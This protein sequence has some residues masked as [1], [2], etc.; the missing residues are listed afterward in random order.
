[1]LEGSVENE[2]TRRKAKLPRRKQ[3]K[4]QKLLD[5]ASKTGI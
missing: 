1:M 3:R 2:A 5:T 4:S